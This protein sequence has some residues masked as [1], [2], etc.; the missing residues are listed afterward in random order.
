MIKQL[1]PFAVMCLMLAVLT[2]KVT[3]EYVSPSMNPLD[4]TTSSLKRDCPR[5]T[6]APEKEEIEETEEIEEKKQV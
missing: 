6:S 5:Q 4:P 1:G 2:V 3:K